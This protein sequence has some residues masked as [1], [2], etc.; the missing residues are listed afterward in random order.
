MKA[1]NL[2]RK[3]GK[4]K[5]KTTSELKQLISTRSDQNPNFCLFLGS[6]ASRSSGIQTAGE[7]VQKW[8]ANVYA[9]LKG[10]TEECPIAQMKQWLSE[11]AG[12]W[13]DEN[14]E[15]ASLIERI[16][17]LP[18]NRRKFIETEVA[19]KIPSIAYA[20]LV[21]IAEAGL[22]RTIFT[23]NFDDLL[24]EAF[25][26]FSSERALICAHDSSV[27]TISIT[28]RRTKIIKLHGDYLFDDLK[29]TSRET[30][31]LDENMK[32]KFEEFLK[33]YG[34]IIAGY[35]GSDK[36]ITRILEDM[37][38]KPMYLQN[39]LFWCF[40]EKDE[41]T[42]EALGILD[43]PNSFYVL[44][45][46]FDELMADL[47]SILSIDATPFNSK[48]ASDRASNII[49]TY[50]QNDHLK[51]S[52]SQTIRKH[53]EALESD[54]NATL[55]S[56]LMKDLNAERIASAGLTDKNLLVFLEIERALKNRNPELA[57]IR[58]GEELARTAD[59]R[60]KEMLLRRRFLC[61]V[62]LN[63]FHEAKDAVKQ[64]L[65]LEPANLY[66][67]L[68][69]CSLMENR[70][71]RI[72]YLE[73]LKTRQPFSAPV[74]NQ[75]AEELSEALKKRDKVR[76]GLRPDDVV[77]AL[78]RSL[79]VDPSLENDAWSQLFRFYSD[80]AS[81][82]KH[83]ELLGE[84]IDK[85][86]SQDAFDSKTSAMLLRYCRKFKTFN[87]KG[88]SLFEYLNDAY[89]NH[90]PRDRAAHLDV[91]V[92]AC[93]EFDMH[94]LLRPL[95]EE[96]RDNE[97]L[98]D[99]AQFAKI[100]MD[101]YYDVFRDLPGAISHGREFLNTNKKVSVEKKLLNFYL[102][103][104]AIQ[105][106]RELHTKLKGALDYG[107]WLGLEAS[108]LEYEGRYQDAIDVIESIPD[109]RDSK[110]KYI[111][112]LA[113][114][115]LKMGVPDRA[116]KRCKEFL[117]ERSF[118]ITFEAEIVNYEYGKKMIGKRIDKKRVDE[119]AQHAEREI[120]KGVCY[121]LLGKDDD[122]LELFRREADKRFSRIDDCLQWPAISRHKTELSAIRDELL[123]AKR[124]LTDLP[125]A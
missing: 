91:F 71:E 13:Y 43:R 49:E 94:R 26:Q 98:K 113:Y 75:Y 76:S 106:A 82:T 114:L 103:D 60:F 102:N 56:D 7:M 35:S 27:H 85:H 96:A 66:M 95:L 124:S 67:S 69:E 61:S 64:M 50:L 123:K 40:R 63:R 58:L 33:E 5:H 28:S 12:E 87:Y 48:L 15:Y 31:S 68:N 25:Y 89:K 73:Q 20:Y 62:R 78:K 44:T 29:N 46:G 37:S 72:A 125:K 100:M 54:K 23:T 79:D 14:R 92:D 109:K 52:S 17:P 3:I 108:I 18:T 101:V 30:Q 4:K 104:N 88:K 121:S 47:Y 10:V 99:D 86:L 57:L 51:S 118:S 65:A 90:F 115:E 110:E 120:V 6:G 36:S 53:L 74:L 41:I 22:L 111:S 116:V 8:R 59:R 97:E 11:S 77:A 93:I 39:G 21:R 24:N 38:D 84:I 55:L 2:E 42:K 122:A 45:P 9:D 70:T 119:V 83:R 81:T 107:D 34:L 32:E 117:D 80:Q 112:Q 105:R 19:D 16:Y 1:A